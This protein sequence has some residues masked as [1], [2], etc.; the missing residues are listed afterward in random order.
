MSVSPCFPRTVLS[1]PLERENV[2]QLLILRKGKA[3]AEKK[4]SSASRLQDA[5]A[6]AVQDKLASYLPPNDELDV[7]PPQELEPQHDNKVT[8]PVLDVRRFF[9]SLSFAS[10]CVI[11]QC[12]TSLSLSQ[13]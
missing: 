2:E 7:S 12:S 5:T 8:N 11:I 10:V 1:F 13:I 4:S 9:L 6:L 3:K